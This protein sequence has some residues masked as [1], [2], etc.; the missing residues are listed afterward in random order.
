VSAYRPTVTPTTILRTHMPCFPTIV[1]LD[2]YIAV[3]I[4]SREALHASL[5]GRELLLHALIFHR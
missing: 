3:Y 2:T 5:Q 1:G 4:H